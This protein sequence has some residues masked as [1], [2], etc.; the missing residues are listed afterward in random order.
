MSLALCKPWSETA[1]QHPWIINTPFSTNPKHSLIPAAVKK[2]H[3]SPAKTSA[4]YSKGCGPRSAGVQ[5]ERD[6]PGI[7]GYCIVLWNFHYISFAYSVLTLWVQLIQ[8]H[9]QKLRASSRE[10]V[11][12]LI[13]L[14]TGHTALAWDFNWSTGRIPLKVLWNAVRLV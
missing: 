12:H 8:I 1:V 9:Y 13:C 7:T 3:S 10:C 14:M 11:P 4:S 2:I 5:K 6:L